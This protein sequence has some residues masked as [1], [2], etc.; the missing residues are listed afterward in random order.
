MSERHPNDELKMQIKELK[1]K[2]KELEAKQKEEK[3]NQRSQKRGGLI[4][5]CIILAVLTICSSAVMYVSIKNVSQL[6][7]ELNSCESSL[8]SYKTMYSELYGALTD[9]S[10]QILSLQKENEAMKDK[11][12]KVDSGDVSYSY[13]FSSV[14]D[15]LV[16]VQKNPNAYNNK[17]L[18]PHAPHEGE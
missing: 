15:F 1:A 9:A 5:L 10:K 6:R 3:K 8:E 2:K 13:S 17:Q 14:Y 4:A 12:A 11:L 7:S 18:R 16:A